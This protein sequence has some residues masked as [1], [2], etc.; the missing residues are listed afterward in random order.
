MV[1]TRVVNTSIEAPSLESANG[2]FTKAPTE[3]PIQLRCCS[4]NDSVQSI[5]SSPSNSLCE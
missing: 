2:N 1:S 5:W 3:R 4:F